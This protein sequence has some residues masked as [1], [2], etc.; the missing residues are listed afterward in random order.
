M[1]K[2]YERL[3]ATGEAFRLRGDDAP[4]DEAVGLCVGVSSQSL[5]N[6]R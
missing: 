6:S 4:D 3:C 1:S 2:D 5:S